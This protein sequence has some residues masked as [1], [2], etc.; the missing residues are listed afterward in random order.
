MAVETGRE[1]TEFK[2]RDV[3]KLPVFERVAAG[4]TQLMNEHVVDYFSL[5]AKWVSG[6]D[7]FYLLKVK[8]DKTLFKHRADI[9][10]SIGKH[11]VSPYFDQNGVGSHFRGCYRGNQGE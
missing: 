11:Q 4:S 9:N 7:K 10:A 1:V 6:K 2:G 5:P 8:G 3:V